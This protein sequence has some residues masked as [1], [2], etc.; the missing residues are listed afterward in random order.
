MTGRLM[1]DEN[2]E[3]QWMYTNEEHHEA[4]A[5]TRDLLNGLRESATERMMKTHQSHAD[6]MMKVGLFIM[7]GFLVIG[8]LIGYDYALNGIEW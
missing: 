8:G 2:G 4:I 1:K 3:W 7:V 6:S 5:Q